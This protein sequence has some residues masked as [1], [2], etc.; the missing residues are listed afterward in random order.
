MAVVPCDARESPQ[1]KVVIEVIVLK[2]VIEVIVLNPVEPHVAVPRAHVARDAVPTMG[3][4]AR[5][6]HPVW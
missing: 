5:T 1:E 3:A 6:Y 2:D 4:V